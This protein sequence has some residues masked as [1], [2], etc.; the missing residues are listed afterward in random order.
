[1]TPKTEAQMHRRSTALRFGN[2]MSTGTTLATFVAATFLSVGT[3]LAVA[4]T[5][6]VL[7]ELTAETA[8]LLV[9]GSVVLAAATV[10]L[11]SLVRTVVRPKPRPRRAA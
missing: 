1:M 10:I 3:L 4:G 2:P 11:R 9:A 5:M 8:A 6:F 7:A